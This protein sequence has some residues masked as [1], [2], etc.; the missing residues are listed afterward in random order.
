MYNFS[1]RLTA[2][3]KTVCSI[4][5]NATRTSVVRAFGRD[6]RKESGTRDQ[7]D[8]L[9]AAPARNGENVI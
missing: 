7:D 8:P 2:L 1:N 9:D 3:A 4:R 6:P 5:S